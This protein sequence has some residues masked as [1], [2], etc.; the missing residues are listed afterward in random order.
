MYTNLV[1]MAIVS[2]GMATPLI[3][4]LMDLLRHGGGV[5]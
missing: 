1:I 3:R 4:R 5:E 2:T